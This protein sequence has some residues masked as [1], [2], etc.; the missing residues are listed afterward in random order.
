MRISDWSSDV[1]SSDLQGA[2]PGGD[3]GVHP[4]G[5]RRHPAGQPDCA[6]EGH[7]R[8]GRH[9]EGHGARPADAPGEARKSVGW[10]KSV[11]VRLDLGGRSSIEK[12][13][14]QMYSIADTRDRITRIEGKKT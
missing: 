9:H 11:S 6:A 13:T 10:G 7:Q 12:Q 2:D 3:R 8:H 1:C 14:E 4:A 5:R